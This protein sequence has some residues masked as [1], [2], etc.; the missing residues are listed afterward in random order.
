[1]YIQFS[2]QYCI[3]KLKI[4][5]TMR[6]ELDLILVA[7]VT[8]F[9]FILFFGFVL[10]NIDPDNKLEGYVIAISFIGIF[11]TF[12]G[13]YLGAKIS[14]EYAIKVANKERELFKQER[15]FIRNVYIRKYIKFNSIMFSKV[16]GIF[17]VLKNLDVNVETI[18]RLYSIED[19]TLTFP[20]DNKVIKII[21]LYDFIYEFNETITNI[22]NNEKCI[23]ADDKYTDALLRIK[24]SS[25]RFLNTFKREELI[26][27]DIQYLNYYLDELQN[28]CE[29]IL[30]EHD[31]FW[32]RQLNE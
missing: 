28:T 20:E 14:G 19:A 26:G 21:E 30:N 32:D 13:A 18:N 3:I 2:I 10:S 8:V 22:V 15:E 27:S 25:K 5:E 12:G 6:G 11:A 16:H 23:V 17:T 4:G 7:I 1:M 31:I 24:T 9:G 29:N